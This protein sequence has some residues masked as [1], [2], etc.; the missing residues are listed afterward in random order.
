[1]STT[2]THV[3]SQN[4]HETLLSAINNDL[5]AALMDTVLVGSV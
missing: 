1:M 5:V 3:P 2:V 4:S